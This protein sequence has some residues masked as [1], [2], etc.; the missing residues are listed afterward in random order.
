MA[1]SQAPFSTMNI[2]NMKAIRDTK[3]ERMAKKM[4]IDE[5]LCDNLEKS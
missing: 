2:C 3:L 1:T 5:K 4:W